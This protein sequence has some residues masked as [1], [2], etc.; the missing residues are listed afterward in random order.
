MGNSQL[1]MV[2]AFEHCG[3]MEEERFEIQD[4]VQKRSSLSSFL[5]L[6]LSLATAMNTARSLPP[7]FLPSFPQRQDAAVPVVSAA[8]VSLPSAAAAVSW[9]FVAEKSRA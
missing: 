2:S 6:P 4:P 7:S 9:M 3:A 8:I 1:E 5:P